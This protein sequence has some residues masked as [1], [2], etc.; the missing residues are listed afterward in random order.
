[1]CVCMCMCVDAG[2]ASNVQ[3]PQ[4]MMVRRECKGKKREKREEAEKQIDTL[5]FP[6]KF[7]SVSF[8]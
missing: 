5:V 1:M 7:E 4:S 6:A 8:M 3:H 2:E